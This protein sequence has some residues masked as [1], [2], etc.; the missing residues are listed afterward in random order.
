LT[1]TSNMSEINSLFIFL[2]FQ[3]VPQKGLEPL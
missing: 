1:G 2:S 3:K